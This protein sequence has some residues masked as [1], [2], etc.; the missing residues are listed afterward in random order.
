LAA[1]QGQVG[2]GFVARGQNTKSAGFA[3]PNI[4]AKEVHVLAEHVDECAKGELCR[5]GVHER[6]PGSLIAWLEQGPPGEAD[7]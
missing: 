4:L 7:Q 6:L 2:C 1:C 3:K 5:E